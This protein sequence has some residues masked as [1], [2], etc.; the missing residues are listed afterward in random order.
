MPRL[1][2]TLAVGVLVLLLSVG[3]T[4][5]LSSV[6]RLHGEVTLDRGLRPTRAVMR[7]QR[8]PTTQVRPIHAN[9][10][11]PPAPAADGV[12]AAEP[13]VTYAPAPHY[14]IRALREQRQGV[15]RIRVRLGAHGR[16]LDAVVQQSSGD[17][18]LDQAA[19]RAV[20]AWTFDMPPHARREAVLPIRFHIDAPRP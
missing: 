20:H 19:L 7:V 5:L 2:T 1:R 8:R 18:E 14:P 12:R 11:S 13:R 6:Q 3:A 16:V 15:V 10:P 4:A 9:R 17:P